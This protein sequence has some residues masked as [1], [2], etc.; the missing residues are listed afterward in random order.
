MSDNRL[1]TLK[2]IARELGVNYKTVHYYKDI[3]EEFVFIQFQGRRIRYLPENIF[4][5]AKILELKDE[6]Y[7]NEGIRD[8]FNSLKSENLKIYLSDD[9]DVWESGG[10][11]D[12]RS[13]CL[14]VQRSGD[15]TDRM[16]GDPAGDP[17]EQSED[18]EQSQ[19]PIDQA[20]LVSQLREEIQ[21]QL[22]TLAADQVQNEVSRQLTQLL[23]TLEDCL[24]KMSSETNGAMTQVYKAIYQAQNGMQTLEDRL[25]KLEE[26]LGE[27]RGELIELD[28]IDLNQ[29]QLNKHNLE[30]EMDVD[31]QDRGPS[32]S[33][34]DEDCVPNH[35]DLEFVRSSIQDGKPDKTAVIQWIIAEK[36]RN[37][38]LSYG[39]LA[40]ILT[41]ADIPTLSGRDEWSRA[42]VRNL[43]VISS[44]I[45]EVT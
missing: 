13:G 43:A 20:A 2:E 26:A 21:D 34:E 19:Q 32:I 25:G 42:V 1:L 10:L 39:Q 36:E 41:N 9:L 37:P 7:C 14:D 17:N 27:G 44:P 29:L 30:V 45:Q 6:W 22:N 16:S 18:E 33:G 11:T 15:L 8:Q 31:G 5:I 23:S 3:F 28:Q 12:W 35:A 24:L 38:D 4:L 40:K